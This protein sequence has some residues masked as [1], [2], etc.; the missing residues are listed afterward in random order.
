[1]SSISAGDRPIMAHDNRLQQVFNLVNNARDA[2]SEKK[3]RLPGWPAGHIR[4]RT[5]QQGDQVVRGRGDGI[6]ISD[7]VRQDLRA[8]P[9]PRTAAP[10][11]PRAHHV[12]NR[13]DRGEFN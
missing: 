7:A 5:F 3:E 9:A 1:M 2:I 10:H 11:G 12:W 6:G 13:K 8:K 4:I